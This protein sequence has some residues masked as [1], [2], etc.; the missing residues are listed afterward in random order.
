MRFVRILLPFLFVRN[1]YTGELE[2]SQ[3]RLLLFS[4]FLVL[5]FLAIVI[6]LGLGA[7]VEYAAT[8]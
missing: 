3:N 4:L 2:M 8:I 6:V 1:W 7:P 5:F